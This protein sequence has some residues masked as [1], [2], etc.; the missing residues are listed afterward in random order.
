MKTIFF[1]ILII[2]MFSCSDSKTETSTR[3]IKKENFIK[4]DISSQ[5]YLKRFIVDTTSTVLYET[6]SFESDKIETLVR[7][8]EITFLAMKDNWVKIKVKN[9]GNI[10]YV[11]KD[12]IW[13]NE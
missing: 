7:N 5:F 13:I 4:E 3:P 10:G 6:P 8:Q 1:S 9:N 2:C 11:I 12:D